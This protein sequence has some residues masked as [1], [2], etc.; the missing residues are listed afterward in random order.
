MQ[1][2][3]RLLR[4][5]VEL[6]PHEREPFFRIRGEEERHEIL[7]L[8][9]ESDLLT[10][11]DIVHLPQ[12]YQAEL[13]ERV[14]GNPQKGMNSTGRVFTIEP[15]HGPIRLPQGLRRNER[16]FVNLT[17]PL[18]MEANKAISAMLLYGPTAPVESNRN[19]VREVRVERP[20][21]EAVPSLQSAPPAITMEDVERMVE[22]RLASERKKWEAEQEEKAAA[23]SPV[24]PP[25]EAATAEPA[26]ET[27]TSKSRSKKKK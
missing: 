5:L 23:P 6:K 22:T 24:D 11:T 7:N 10:C 26:G 21:A 20:A 3:E 16:Q 27:S 9:A 18:P 8:W 17:G 13:I 14:C 15:T 1:Y 25:A 12:P 2:V 4:D 19:K